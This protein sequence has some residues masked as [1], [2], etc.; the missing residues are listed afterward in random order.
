MADGFFGV[1]LK[2]NAGLKH[3]GETNDRGWGWWMIIKR[4]YHSL[5]GVSLSSVGQTTAQEP[6]MHLDLKGQTERVRYDIGVTHS[7]SSV[8]AEPT[9]PS[10]S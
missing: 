5:P 8:H 9:F 6:S 10:V 3:T 4:T 2:R 1:V 7:A